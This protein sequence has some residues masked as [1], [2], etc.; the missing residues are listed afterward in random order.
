MRCAVDRQLRGPK[1]GQ[2]Y[3]LELPIAKQC[4]RPRI[5]Q[6]TSCH[7]NAELASQKST[8]KTRTRRPHRPFQ[9]LCLEFGVTMAATQFASAR[10]GLAVGG[11]RRWGALPM[12][13]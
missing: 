3:R 6:G 9:D 11:S 13:F 8:Y 2:G 7:K 10:L 1:A 5:W 4:N 12:R